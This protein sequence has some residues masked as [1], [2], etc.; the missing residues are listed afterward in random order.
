[1]TSLHLLA[2][3]SDHGVSEW[4]DEHDLLNQALRSINLPELASHFPPVGQPTLDWRPEETISALNVV[5]PLL[6]LPD[7][8][9]AAIFG[10]GSR[11]EV[12]QSAVSEQDL[13]T[14]QQQ[15]LEYGT[16]N[17][18][19]AVIRYDVVADP[20][21]APAAA[22][23]Q[24]NPTPAYTALQSLISF[25]QEAQAHGAELQAFEIE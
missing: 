11:K 14:L 24:T 13:A 5:L 3:S 8:P 6:V 10:T 21:S 1:M 4:N 20:S 16:N 25:C 15:V 7:S 2:L 12:L 23:V 22:P 18:G 19:E 17:Q 9:A